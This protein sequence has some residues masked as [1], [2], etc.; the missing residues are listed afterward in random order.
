MSRERWEPVV[1]YEGLYEVSDLGRVRSLDRVIMGA[2]GVPKPHHGRVLSPFKRS[3]C[4]LYVSLWKNGSKIT[5]A[6]HRLVAF[7]FLPNPH[8]KPEVNHIDGCK[9]N[10]RAENLEWCT[11]SENVKHAFMTGLCETSRE[12]IA[13]M[14][15]RAAALNEKRVVRSDGIEFDSVKKAADASGAHHQNVSRCCHGRARATGG[16][17]FRFKNDLDA[18]TMGGER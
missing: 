1:G 18:R 7:A 9:T 13:E 5:E 3:R 6:V 2:D 4:Y 10:N 16:Y 11:R 15:R 8:G 17:G 12:R 14:S